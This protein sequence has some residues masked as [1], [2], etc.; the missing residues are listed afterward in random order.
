MLKMKNLLI[1]AIRYHSCPIQLMITNMNLAVNLTKRLT[2]KHALKTLHDNKPQIQY[3]QILT[4]EA[5]TCIKSL[6][7][8]TWPAWPGPSLVK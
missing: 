7:V 4:R 6:L 8:P 1:S 3:F 5:T 2:V